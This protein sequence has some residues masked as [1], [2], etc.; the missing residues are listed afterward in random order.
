MSRSSQTQ[1]K[2]QRENKLREKAQ[3]KRERR[4]QR[5]AEKKLGQS[6]GGQAADD[7]LLA[8][9]IEAPNG[10]LLGPEMADIETVMAP[11]LKSRQNI[12]GGHTYAAHT[13]S[14][15]VGVEALHI[16][17]EEQLIQR[18]ERVGRYLLDGFGRCV[19]DDS[20]PMPESPRDAP[21]PAIGSARG[22]S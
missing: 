10:D 9:E 19:E 15:A 12:V 5:Q 16:L 21:A 4:Q 13:L 14:C 22:G 8:S 7:Q 18:S 2:R 17:M 11:I 6:E 3:L 1:Q 20:G